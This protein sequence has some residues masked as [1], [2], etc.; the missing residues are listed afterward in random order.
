MTSSS[1]ETGPQAEVCSE[2]LRVRPARLRVA[3]WNVQ[4]CRRGIEAVADVLA[5]L[6]ADLVA[7]QEVERGT[8]AAGG[9]DQ[10]AHLARRG[11]FPHVL[12]LPTLARDGGD[13]GIALASRFPLRPLPPLALPVP[14]GAEPRLLGLAELDVGVADIAA[15]G[16]ARSRP[17]TIAFTHL[18]HRP[19]RARARF[20]QA[21][22]IVAR[23]GGEER[24]LL[25][26]DFN[27]REGTPMHRTLLTQGFR[28]LFQ[29]VG[30]GGGGTH[31]PL[32]RF[33][34]ALRIDFLF[35]SRSIGARWARVIETRA[36]D[37]HALVGE[38]A[39]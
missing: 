27:G 11:G 24:C 20:F 36:S 18:S 29:E 13:Y 21:Q 30:E 22:R 28:D 17:L 19:D 8:R 25:L 12:F 16:P 39:V 32:G 6:R 35:A 23:L 14:R 15:P 3:S 38:L 37:H 26:G 10:A 2:R 33:L 7:L 9:V 5:A 1:A 34:P 4:A 31:A